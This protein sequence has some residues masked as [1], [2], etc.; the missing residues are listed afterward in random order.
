MSD[1]P[2]SRFRALHDRF[3]VLPN[4]WDRG[5]ALRLEALGFRALATTSSGFAASLG[6]R[7]GQVS[8][9][10]LVEHVAQLAQLVDIPINVDAERCFAEDPA[11]VAETVSLL[12][13]AGAGGVSIEDWD[14]ATGVIDDVAVALERVA[15]AVD[16]GRR[17]D[18][19]ITARCENL[20]RGV[21]DLEDTVARLVAYRDAGAEVLYAPGLVEP[22][23]IA[24]VVALGRPVNVLAWPGTP[25]A[26]AL[27]ELGAIR[28][29]TGGA[30]ARIAYEAMED[31]ARA[32]L[33]GLDGEDHA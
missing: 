30:L 4:P 3:F 31:A 8:R 28:M 24:R 12:A 7:D 9:D 1:T 25:A 23:D 32:L 19:V 29:S 2:G 15:A 14:P 17:H 16:A 27:A 6:R 13:A 5:S 21:P 20:I 10:E 22:A 33:D 18:V 11:G 26:P